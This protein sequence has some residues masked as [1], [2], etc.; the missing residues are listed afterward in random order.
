MSL[1]SSVLSPIPFTVWGIDIIGLFPRAKGDQRYVLVAIDYM[2]KWAEAK[3]M[4]TINQ[5]DCIKFMDFIVMRFGIP[6]VLISDN[7][8]QFV[9]YD[10][11][12]YLKDL[13]IKHKKS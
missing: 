8:P 11:E 9:G 5:Y 12:A 13:G 10:F 3:V 6:I 4:R 7:D 2:T 1:P